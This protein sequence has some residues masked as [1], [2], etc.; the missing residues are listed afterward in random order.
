MTPPLSIRLRF[1]D[2]W[3][4]VIPTDHDTFTIDVTDVTSLPV[5]PEA[6]RKACKEFLRVLS[7]LRQ[8]VFFDEL[9][10]QNEA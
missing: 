6:R 4:T 3:V 2:A 5:T 10:G 9:G 1:G 8:Q 7:G